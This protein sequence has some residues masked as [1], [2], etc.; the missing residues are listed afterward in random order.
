M[1]NRYNELQYHL[2]VPLTNA[3]LETKVIVKDSPVDSTPSISE[4][5]GIAYEIKTSKGFK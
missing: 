3:E 4:L 2:L 1:L 5:K